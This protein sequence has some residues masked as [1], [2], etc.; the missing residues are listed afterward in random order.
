MGRVPQGGRGGGE[1]CLR[2]GGG[3]TGRGGV[4][5]A[6]RAEGLEVGTLEPRLTDINLPALMHAVW[7]IDLAILIPQPSLYTLFGGPTARQ[8]PFIH[9]RKVN[10]DAQLWHPRWF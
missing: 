5:S 1:D 10:L 7:G 3:R 6:V 4:L 2:G 9:P 8:E